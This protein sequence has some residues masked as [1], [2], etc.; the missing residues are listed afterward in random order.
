[1]AEKVI[2]MLHNPDLGGVDDALCAELTGAVLA[3]PGPLDITASP[4]APPRPDAYARSGSA[5][6]APSLTAS[7]SMAHGQRSSRGDALRASLAATREAVRASLADPAGAGV[8]PLTPTQAAMGSNFLAEAGVPLPLPVPLHH[9][10]EGEHRSSSGGGAW[11]DVVGAP[12]AARA[13]SA[14]LQPLP[15]L[16]PSLTAAAKQAASAGAVTKGP[17]LAAKLPS[18]LAVAAAAGAAGLD[19]GASPDQVELLVRPINV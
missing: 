10:Q 4:L 18:P 6:G 9:H 1:M 17:G 3:G 8:Q 13:A 19:T 15:P 2:D 5:R 11:D 14:G 12:D 16:A 7:P